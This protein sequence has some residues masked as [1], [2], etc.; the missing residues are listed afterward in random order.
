MGTGKRCGLVWV[1][2]MLFVALILPTGCAPKPGSDA[3]LKAK[4]NRAV[5]SYLKQQGIDP[6]G[7]REPV[8]AVEGTPDGRVIV[9]LNFTDAEFV[10]GQPQDEVVPGAPVQGF[11]LGQ[12]LSGTLAGTF[13]DKRVEIVG[14]DGKSFW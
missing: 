3:D 11:V 12:G 6:S 4:A 13:Y 1:V 7:G 2:P 10:A 8:S 14:P 5:S 9:H